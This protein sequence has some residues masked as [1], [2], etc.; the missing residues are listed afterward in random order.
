MGQKVTITLTVDAANLQAI[1][2]PKQSD[3]ENNTT[4]TDDNGGSPSAINANFTSV[5][6]I[7]S[8]V[9][10]VG[11][12]NDPGYAIVIDSVVYEPVNKGP[13]V[14]F[15]N[16]P[17]LSRTSRRHGYVEAKVNN[18]QNLVGA[19]YG[20]HI[21][22]KIHVLGG[23]FLLGWVFGKVLGPFE[24]DPKLRGKANN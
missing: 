3:I 11:V 4:L 20:Y 2:S 22:F 10:W 23:C 15:F 17:L 6:F 9:R 7:D 8:D 13:S 21:N 12:T 19:L 18:D 16:A 1:P 5:V 24:I 14:D